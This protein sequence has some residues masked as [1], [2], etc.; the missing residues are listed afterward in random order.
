MKAL[1]SLV[2]L[3]ATSLPQHPCDSSPIVS[4]VD[5]GGDGK[6]LREVKDGERSRQSGAITLDPVSIISLLALGK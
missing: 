3:V 2:L 6:L 5:S 4:R 1:L